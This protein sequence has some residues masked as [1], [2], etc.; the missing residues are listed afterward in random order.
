MANQIK[1]GDKAP[2]FTLPD[3]DMTP[4]SLHEFRGQKVVLTFFVGAFTG[5]CTMEACDFRDSMARLTDMDAQVVGISVND[6]QSNREFAEK[7]RL[8]YTILSDSKRE[9]I[10]LYGL[11]QEFD[12]RKAVKPDKRAIFVINEEGKVSYAWVP[13]RL[14]VEPN[15]DDVQHALEEMTKQAAFS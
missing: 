15:Y 11:Q 1:V 4:R 12:P 13:D 8:P 14:R 9:V 2:D 5:Q 10:R 3:V 7:N 6:P